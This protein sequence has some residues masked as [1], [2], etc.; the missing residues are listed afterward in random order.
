MLEGNT[1]KDGGS[2]SERDT[3]RGK[4]RKTG[5]GIGQAKTKREAR[6]SKRGFLLLWLEYEKDDRAGKLYNNGANRS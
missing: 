2:E 4:F 3:E 5:E 6:T 1:S